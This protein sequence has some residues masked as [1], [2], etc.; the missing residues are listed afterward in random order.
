MG[1]YDGSMELRMKIQCTCDEAEKLVRQHQSS[2]HPEI[3]CQCLECLYARE[4]LAQCQAWRRV[5]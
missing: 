3:Q 4:L 2:A 5:P 1:I